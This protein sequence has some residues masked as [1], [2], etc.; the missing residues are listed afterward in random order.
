MAK[1]NADKAEAQF[2]SLAEAELA[3]IAPALAK[4]LTD[5]DLETQP[6]EIFFFPV[7]SVGD[8]RDLFQK[9]IGWKS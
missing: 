2:K 4:A 6:V 1:V 8:F 7:P 9:K 3:K 5:A